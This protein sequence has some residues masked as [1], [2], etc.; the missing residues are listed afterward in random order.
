MNA[1][2]RKRIQDILE[3]INKLDE[4]KQDIYYAIEEV[5]DEEQ[6][7]LDN[8]PDSLRYSAKGDDMEARVDALDRA[9]SDI[10]DVEFP[11]D[12]LEEAVA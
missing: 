5:R 10:E 3:M 2:R 8:L 9:M 11:T 6:E 7:A 4:L 1:Q 12:A